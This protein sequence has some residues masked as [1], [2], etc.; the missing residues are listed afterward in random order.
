MLEAADEPPSL[1]ELHAPGQELNRLGVSATRDALIDLAH[2]LAGDAPMPA[3]AVARAEQLAF[4]PSSPLC[5]GASPEALR[6]AIAEVGAASYPSAAS[7]RLSAPGMLRA[8]A[9]G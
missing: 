6:A 3:R 4:G 5:G 7:S 9:A 1:W 2:Q 8:H